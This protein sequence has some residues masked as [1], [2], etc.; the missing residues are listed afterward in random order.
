[1]YTVQVRYPGSGW[2]TVVSLP[3]QAAIRAAARAYRDAVSADGTS[4]QQ[5][6]LVETR[7]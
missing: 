1:V 6:R 2:V 5:V 7:G 4:P 3:R